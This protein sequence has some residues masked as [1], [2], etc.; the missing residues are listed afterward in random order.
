MHKAMLAQFKPILTDRA[1]AADLSLQLDM[2]LN[3]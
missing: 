3:D 2:V 1:G